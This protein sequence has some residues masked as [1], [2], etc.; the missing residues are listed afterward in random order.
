MM[1]FIIT[2]QESVNFF[3]K[4]SDSKDFRLWRPCRLVAS[5]QPQRG[6]QEW[7]SERMQRGKQT[8]SKGQCWVVEIITF[9]DLGDVALSIFIGTFNASNILREKERLKLAI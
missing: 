1:H 8:N 6:G 2:E 7:G 4:W 3:C 9:Q 5:K